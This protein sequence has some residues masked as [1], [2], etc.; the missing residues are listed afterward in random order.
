MSPVAGTVIKP[1][2]PLLLKK[3]IVQTKI[4]NENLEPF[5]TV[6]F[7]I[8][9]IDLTIEILPQPL[10]EEASSGGLTIPSENA[11]LFLNLTNQS[12]RGI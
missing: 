7:K 6:K 9:P 11:P 2:C 8:F 3:K 12:R 10:R 4:L 5:A 1:A